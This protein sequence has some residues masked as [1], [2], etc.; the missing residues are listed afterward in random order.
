M[1]MTGL[2]QII[3]E[4]SSASFLRLANVETGHGLADNPGP[5][6]VVK[7]HLD[8]DPI[9]VFEKQLVLTHLWNDPFTKGNAH[10]LQT[11]LD[12]FQPFAT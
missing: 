4:G 6:H 9:G 5:R 8:G 7:D 10:R 1:G 3:R 2:V 12:R 11:D